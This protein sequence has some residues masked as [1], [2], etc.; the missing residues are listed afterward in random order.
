M[1]LCE[2]P[3]TGIGRIW[4]DGK[5]MDL[6]GVTW[7]WYPGDE[8][9]TADPADTEHVGPNGHRVGYNEHGDK[10]EWIPND[11]QPGELW[12]LLLRRN[13]EQI[14]REYNVSQMPVVGP[15]PP[16]VIGEVAGSVNE[17]A[18]ISAVFEGRAALTDAVSKH[19]EPPLPL[20]GS[21]ESLED[22]LKALSA[23]DAV[24]V[25]EDG[26]PLGVLTR[27][28]LLGVHV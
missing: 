23:S 19:M 26:K 12:P 7:R 15:E 5:P 2:G 28:D 21:G 4:A 10:V 17:R 16:V 13:D 1:A 9:Q 24:M 25:I 11:D 18:L 20:L 27:H 8:A 22:A 6:S 3:I 14:L